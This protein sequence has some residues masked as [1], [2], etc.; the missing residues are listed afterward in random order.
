MQTELKPNK[1]SFQITKVN[2]VQQRKTRCWQRS[3][4]PVNN[5]RLFYMT[6]KPLLSAQAALRANLLFLRKEVASFLKTMDISSLSAGNVRGCVPV[7]CWRMCKETPLPSSL[8]KEKATH[9]CTALYSSR[10]CSTFCHVH[11]LVL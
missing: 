8:L 7:H 9:C 10:L 6:T 4:F 2:S 5:I 3:W 11:S 1:V